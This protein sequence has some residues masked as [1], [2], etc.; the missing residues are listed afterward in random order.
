MRNLVFVHG[1]AQQAKDAVALKKQ[2]IQV[3]KEGLAK[4]G[5]VLPVSEDQVRFPY[6]G[7][8]LAAL[9][10]GLSPEEA[11][12]I[13]VRGEDQDQVQ[14]E[15]IR[16]VLEEIRIQAGITRAQLREAAGDQ[17]VDR[18]PLQWEWFQGILKAIDRYI[19]GGSGASVALF[20]NDVYDYLTNPAVREQINTGVRQA[21]APGVS[22]VLVGHSLGS[23]VAYDIL[24][25]L[26]DQ[27]GWDVP[28]FVTVGCPLAVTKIKAAVAPIGH[29]R[30]AKKWFN[31]MDDADVVALYPLNDKHFDV[32]PA[33]ENKTDVHNR[34]QNRHG[35]AGYLNDKDVAKRI[36]D[37]L[38]A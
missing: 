16:D 27:E 32:S 37:A 35:I 25:Q 20:T 6:Y 23:V 38:V 11:A 30:C 36:Y 4:N 7:D 26:G 18:G 19:P 21:F 31:A 1:R 13:V 34:T 5:L 2:W 8:T 12:A 15:F 10:E 29:P 17:V 22:T 24:R 33:I 9:S 14:E 28:L 3:L